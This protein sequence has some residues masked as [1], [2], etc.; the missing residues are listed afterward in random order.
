VRVAKNRFAHIAVDRPN[1]NADVKCSAFVTNR[2]SRPCSI[3][4]HP[5][6]IRN[7]VEMS[8]GMNGPQEMKSVSRLFREVSIYIL[9]RIGLAL[10]LL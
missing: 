2:H 6:I 8:C 5:A 10:P 3:G 1:W 7:S 9:H 4:V